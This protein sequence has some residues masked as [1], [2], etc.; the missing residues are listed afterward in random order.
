MMTPKWTDCDNQVRVTGKT[1]T[2]NLSTLQ[3]NTETYANSADPDETAR[4]E[5]SHQ[6]LHCLPFCFSVYTETPLFNEGP[7]QIQRW[8]RPLQELGG[9]RVNVVRVLDA[10]HSKFSR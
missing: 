1:L 9:E 8:K 6:D 2:F 4:N 3:T 5:P 7:A 10:D